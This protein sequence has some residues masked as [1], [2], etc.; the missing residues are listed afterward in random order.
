MVQR[1]VINRFTIVAFPAI[2]YGFQMF[3]L[4]FLMLTCFK[5]YLSDEAKKKHTII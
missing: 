2:T 4:K 1:A 3:A 5:I